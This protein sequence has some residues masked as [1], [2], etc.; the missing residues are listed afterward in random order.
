MVV[1]IS[2]NFQWKEDYTMQ[3]KKLGNFQQFEGTQKWQGVFNHSGSSNIF[4]FLIQKFT[5]FSKEK[6][7]IFEK[8]VWKIIFRIEFPYYFS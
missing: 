6:T 4:D 3:D 5:P 7:Q 2:W 8:N 1:K